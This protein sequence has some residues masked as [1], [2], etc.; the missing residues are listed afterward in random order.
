MKASHLMLLLVVY[1]A[2][3]IC[4]QVQLYDLNI[5]TKAGHLNGGQILHTVLAAM[6]P[7]ELPVNSSSL[8]HTLT[9]KT[10]R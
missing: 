6:D 5:E 7:P 10:G 4:W 2:M 9:R 3:S 8:S 1:E